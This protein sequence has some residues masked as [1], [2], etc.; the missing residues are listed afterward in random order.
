[1]SECSAHGPGIDWAARARALSAQ[2]EAAAD[3]IEDVGKVPSDVMAALHDAGLFRLCLPRSLGGGE[4]SP[5]SINAV[6]QTIA[7]ADASTAWC[8]GQALGCSFA[9]G[10]VAPEIAREIFGPP[11]A[12]LAW[13]PPNNRARAVPVEGGYSLTGSWSFAS[14]IRNATWIGAH[15]SVYEPDGTLR[16]SAAGRPVFTTMLIPASSVAVPP[17][18]EVM[19]LQGTGSDDYA[20]TDLFVP[21]AYSYTRDIARDRHGPGP[22]YRIAQTTFYGMAFAGVALGIGRASLD[23]FIA[24]AADKTPGY[25]TTTLRDNAGI[26]LQVARCEGHLGGARAFLKE[27]MTEMWETVCRE[28]EMT[29]DQRARLRIACT[30]A[31]ERARKVV[32]FTYHAAG[33]TAILRRNPFERRFRDMHTVSQQ[34]QA[35]PSN[36]EHAGMALLGLEPGPRV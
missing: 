30:Y 31:S 6:L 18:W 15:A 29:L 8:L 17:V 19:G 2:I 34:I 22:L 9:A 35:A 4:A 24:L 26:Q 10:F 13:G 21:Q 28:E 12:V 16:M 1:M 14:G 32:D 33:A 36:F 7:A 11:D 3:R 5:L 27:M 25:T 23:A 20:V